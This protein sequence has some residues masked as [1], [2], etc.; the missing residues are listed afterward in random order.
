M[1][2]APGRAPALALCPNNIYTIRTK[3][4]RFAFSLLLPCGPA[5]FGAEPPADQRG[6]LA[7]PKGAGGGQRERGAGI[8]LPRTR[9]GRGASPPATRVSLASRAEAEAARAGR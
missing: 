4:E 6:D 8:S 3:C 9:K 2:R 7:G 5:P 1:T